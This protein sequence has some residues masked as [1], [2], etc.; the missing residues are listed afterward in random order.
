M[1]R[2]TRRTTG[3]RNSDRSIFYQVLTYV[4][5][6]S[7]I[8]GPDPTAVLLYA[9]VG[10]NWRL[11]YRLRGHRLLVRTLDLDRDWKAIHRDLLGM[12]EELAGIR[13]KLSA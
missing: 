4:D 7:A 5:H 6:L 11:E 8:A 9:S 1:R 10:E 3:P 2:R 13:G 12:A